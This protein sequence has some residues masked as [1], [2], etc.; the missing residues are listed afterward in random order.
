MIFV[1]DSATGGTG[2]I[3]IITH[4]KSDALSSKKSYITLEKSYIIHTCDKFTAWDV[5]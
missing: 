4:D 3:T 5:S 2:V 1:F